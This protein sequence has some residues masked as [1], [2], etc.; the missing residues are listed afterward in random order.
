M[1]TSRSMS[2]ET[3][4][5]SKTALSEAVRAD[6]WRNHRAKAGFTADIDHQP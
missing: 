3:A 1:I 5:C 2:G 4:L 6:F